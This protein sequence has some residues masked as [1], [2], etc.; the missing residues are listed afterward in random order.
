MEVVV[1]NLVK[2][3]GSTKA[4]DDISFS[5]SS[6]NVFG[7]V[8][9][10]GAGKTTTIR[11]L[12]TLLEPTDG[13]AYIDGH[14]VIQ[15]PEKVRSRLGYMPDSLPT[16]ADM[17]VH[18]YVDFYARAAGIDR[19]KRN[20]VVE[21]VEEFTNLMGIRSKFLKSLSKGMKQRVSL[22]RAL[23]HDPAVLILDEPAAGLDP[24]A[25]VELRE[26]LKVLADQGKAILISSHILT[27]LSEICHGAVIVEQGRLLHA[28]SIEELQNGNG[29]DA[30]NGHAI[31]IRA[32]NTEIE[33]LYKFLVQ[34]PLVEKAVANPNNVQI[35]FTG[36]D[37]EAAGL[38][39]TMISGGISIV[40]FRHEKTDLEDIFMNLTKGGVQ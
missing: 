12:A 8:G 35:E 11:I 4:V 2:N 20:S 33:S 14:S 10:N 27:E 29:K 5:F 39:Q 32:V 3:Y 26:L 40:E 28:G 17:T 38:L 25:R 21:G 15:D 31:T 7:F 13:D 37:N 36:S 23:V 9:P 30:K 18:D 6:G 22:A 19:R 16:H 1:K 24:R 34:Q